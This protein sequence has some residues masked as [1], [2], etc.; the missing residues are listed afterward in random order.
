V[1]SLIR[2]QA[3][4]LLRSHRWI[5][6]LVVYALFVWLSGGAGPGGQQ[7]GAALAWSAAALVPA[8]AWLTRL[9]LT[10]EPAE[11][12]ACIAAAG[13]PRRVH[14]AALI[15]AL[16]GGL[17]L[18]L[19]GVIYDL[20]AGRAPG[21]PGGLART[22]AVGLAAALICAGVGSAIGALCNPP[23][24]RTV[25]GAALS[26]IGVVVVTLVSS[27]SPVNAAI[28]VTGTQPRSSAWP[29]GPSLIAAVVLLALCWT[30]STVLAARRGL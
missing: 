4:L 20:V 24:V 16:A 30:V 12:R 9:M 7:L 29:V 13:G 5:G 3:E 21:G 26:T 19:A 11:G 28:R 23:V 18:G 1:I 6:P 17:V 2:Y 25:A 10:A 15:T 27:V 22:V 14:V 8:A